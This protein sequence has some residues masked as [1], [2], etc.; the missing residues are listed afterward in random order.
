[1]SD[2]EKRKAFDERWAQEQQFVRDH[3]RPDGTST[4]DDLNARIERLQQYV[5]WLENMGETW[6][7]RDHRKP[8]LKRGDL[9]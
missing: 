5:Y 4:I 9:D 3:L 7:T 6:L 2:Y 8:F 1:M